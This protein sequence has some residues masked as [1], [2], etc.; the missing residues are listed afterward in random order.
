MEMM[1]RLF[2]LAGMMV[3]SLLTSVAFAQQVDPPM[4]YE[5]SAQ[6][7]A[8]LMEDVPTWEVLKAL[9]DCPEG[10]DDFLKNVNPFISG[11]SSG[12]GSWTEQIDVAGTEVTLFVAWLDDNSFGYDF[13]D[14]NAAMEAI[15]VENNSDKIVYRYDSPV[16]SD[17]G[18]NVIDGGEAERANSLD[19]CVSLAD[20]EGPVITFIYPEDLDPPARVSS[21]TV[22]VLVSVVDPSGVDPTSVTISVNDGKTSNEPMTCVAAG[23]GY[24]CR[25]D[26]ITVGLDGGLYTLTVSAVDQAAT[27]I[28]HATAEVTVDF[29]FTLAD[30]YGD[31][32]PSD[33]DPS[34]PQGCNPTGEENIQAPRGAS[35]PEMKYIFGEVIQVD[36]SHPLAGRC[37]PDA[38]PDPRMLQAPD[39]SWYVAA[40]EEL[41]VFAHGVGVRP[42][43]L[44]GEAEWVISDI[45]YGYNGCFGGTWHYKNWLL[46]D[47][48]GVNSN[49]LFFIKTLFPEFNWVYTGALA[50]CYG[51]F[52]IL[53][54]P[55]SDYTLNLQESAEYLYQTTYVTGMVE[56]TATPYTETCGSGRLLT[57]G[58]S[59]SGWNFIETTGDDAT[60]EA[61]LEWKCDLIDQQFTNLQAVV[62]MAK[63]ELV[64]GK[65]SRAERFINQ[66]QSQ[67]ENCPQDQSLLRAY[68]DLQSAFDAWQKLVFLVNDPNPAG[69]VLGRIGNLRYRIYNAREEIL[70]LGL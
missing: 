52:D 1:K 51:E 7:A 21:S 30:C 2:A 55:R 59:F 56:G 16:F 26:W 69:D 14:E 65:I 35:N 19:L 39:N 42:A 15:G 54:Q 61:V 17:S 45:H 29:G 46:S 31:L 11:G 24:E 28:N 48:Y 62:A 67:A 64:S 66:A 58:K 10:T 25:Y 34:E 22:T 18:L 27:G 8:Q 57:R 12:S 63:A 33:L 38:L 41:H 43:G 37:G 44:P 36:P 4:I 60:P 68:E 49:P 6:Q 50:K 40:K 53:G 70:R 20:K 23:D 5:P 9:G 32:D 13:P 3:L 47:A